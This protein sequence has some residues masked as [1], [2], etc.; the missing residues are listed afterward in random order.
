MAQKFCPFSTIWWCS[1]FVISRLASSILPTGSSFSCEN[2]P[3]A[4]ASAFQADI[5]VGASPTSRSRA[6]SQV[7]VPTCTWLRRH[8]K[9]TQASDPKTDR[10]CRFD[11]TITKA[12]YPAGPEH[13]VVYRDKPRPFF[14]CLVM[15]LASQLDCQSSEMGPIPIRGAAPGSTGQKQ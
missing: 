2:G 12:G 10:W 6:W 14:E 5:I 1:C 8:P 4:T 3:V 15:R 13:V 7:V 11:V 9:R